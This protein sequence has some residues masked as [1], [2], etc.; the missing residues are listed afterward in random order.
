MKDFIL[1]IEK[2]V[3]TQS[4]QNIIHTLLHPGQSYKQ[5]LKS[6]QYVFHVWEN[7]H[8]QK[9]IFYTFS[10]ARWCITLRSAF[11]I[12]RMFFPFLFFLNLRDHFKLH[13]ERY[14]L[15]FKQI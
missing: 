8:P 7:F 3:S 4:F 12:A 6:A 15:L 10:K 11:A 2:R 13:F 5:N 9:Q 1:F 14:L